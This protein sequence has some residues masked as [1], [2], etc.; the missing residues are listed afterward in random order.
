M[1]VHRD[2]WVKMLCQKE[3]R[4]GVQLTMIVEKD[5]ETLGWV[6]GWLVRMGVEMGMEGDWG[7]LR[8]DDEECGVPGWVVAVVDLYAEVEG[9]D[10]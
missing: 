3:E 1:P 4:A 7:D 9:C 8:Y 6:S 5:S 10:C 2:V